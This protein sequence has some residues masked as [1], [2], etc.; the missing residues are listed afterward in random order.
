M[1]RA[2]VLLALLSITGCFSPDYHDSPF[3]CTAQWQFAC[4]D[5][6]QCSMD[7][8][9][10]QST[11]IC[12]K[13]GGGGSHKPGACADSDLEHLLARAEIQGLDDFVF[14]VN[15][16]PSENRIIK[17]GKIRVDPAFMLLGHRS[18]LSLSRSN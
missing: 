8:G 14:M 15:E 17:A 12:V 7:G 5:G 10:D 18:H 6:Y 2:L 13:P 1:P 4:P 3:H 11:G 16:D 9:I